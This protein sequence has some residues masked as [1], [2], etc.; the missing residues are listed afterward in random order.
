[1][2]AVIHAD[3]EAEIREAMSIAEA[4]GLRLVVTGGVEAHRLAGALAARGV[5][6]GDVV[7]LQL[8]N[9]LEAVVAA[10]AVQALGGVINP[11]LPGYRAQEIGHLVE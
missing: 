6:R 10:V 2:P 5:G 3:R 1:M 7:S 4:Y 9:Q 8:P 11:L